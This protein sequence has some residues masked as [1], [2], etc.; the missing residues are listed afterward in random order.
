MSAKNL[1][2]SLSGSKFY[3]QEETLTYDDVLIVPNV[4]SSIRSRFNP[5]EINPY[6]PSGR[7]P[8]VNAPMDTVASPDFILAAKER[9]EAVFTSRFLDAS[10]LSFSPYGEEFEQHLRLGAQPVIGL[11]TNLELIKTWII[12]WDCRHLLLDV[13]NGGN[14]A[15]IDKL[16]ELQPLRELG[17]K[18]W[19]GNV[20][21][22]ETYAALSHLCDFIRVGIG[23]GSVCETRINTGVGIG[24]ITAILQARQSYDFWADLIF[25]NPKYGIDTNRELIYRWEG[26]GWKYPP[27]KICADGGIK[28]NGDI[29]KALAAGAHLAMLGRIF[30]ATQ[31]SRGEKFADDHG[32]IYKIYRGLAS[33]QVA[34][35]SR[36]ANYSVEGAVKRIAVNGSV[37]EL[38]TQIESNL[39]SCMSYVDCRNLEAIYLNSKFCRVSAAVV[40][41]NGAHA[42]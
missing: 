23:G 16:I 21:S 35:Q 40:Q 2:S 37:T 11:D 9:L 19:A 18:L 27:A 15:V 22:I 8:I 41:E 20:A 29:C 34:Q 28:N 26:H 13:A 32:S 10:P 14:V 39:R 42:K 31:E 3:S 12:K 6:T 4:V 33:H 25:N 7:L 17:V 30:A 5:A 38:L 1:A 36:K 24:N